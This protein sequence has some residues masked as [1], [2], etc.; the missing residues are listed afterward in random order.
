MQILTMYGGLA[1]NAL[2]NGTRGCDFAEWLTTGF[3]TGTHAMIVAPGEDGLTQAMLSLPDLAIFGEARLRSSRTSLFTSR[4]FL[5]RR[6]RTKK[7]P[8]RPRAKARNEA[9]PR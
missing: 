7:R 1:I 6:R 5:E 9:C 2:N 4:R 8:P 3:G